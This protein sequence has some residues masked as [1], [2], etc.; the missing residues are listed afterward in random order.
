MCFSC[1]WWP[2]LGRYLFQVT[3]RSWGF[4]LKLGLRTPPLLYYACFTLV[5]FV[6]PFAACISVCAPKFA[7]FVCSFMY[8]RGGGFVGAL[9][10]LCLCLFFFVC[11]PKPM[12]LCLCVCCLSFACDVRCAAWCMYMNDVMSW[13]V[14]VLLQKQTITSARFRISQAADKLSSLFVCFLGYWLVLFLH[15]WTKKCVV[16]YVCGV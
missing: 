6:R 3:A 11:E 4:G 7:M 5:G 1:A 2:P 13:L 12:Y 9:C 8:L 10:S 14:V 16:C 15:A